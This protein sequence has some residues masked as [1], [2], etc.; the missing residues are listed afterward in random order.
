MGLYFEEFEVGAVH[1][2]QRR[3]VTE[4]DIVA[5]AG[6]SWDTNPLHTDKILAVETG[7]P[8]PIAHGALVLSMA[9]GM[10]ANIGYMAGTA[11]AFGGIEEWKFLAPVLAG[12]TIFLRTTVTETRQSQSK[13]DRGIVKRLMEV[14][15]QDGTVVQRGHVAVFV[16]TRDFV[17][18]S[19][20]G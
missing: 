8:A 13:P 11:I 1:Q 15:N 3:T 19:A 20:Q 16:R 6:L 10:S 9:T 12:D 5:F 2:S 17:P 7:F 4:A 14:V 18:R